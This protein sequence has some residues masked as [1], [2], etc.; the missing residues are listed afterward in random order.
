MNSSSSRSHSIFTICLIV[1]ET[2]PSSNNNTDIDVIRISKLNLVDLAGSESAGK[3]GASGDRQ[4]EASKINKSLL[5]LGRVINALT[6]T[7]Q[8]IPYRESKLTRLLQDS[9]GGRTKTCIIATITTADLALDE[10][11]NTL[12]YMSRAKKIKIYQR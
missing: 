10:T 1:K 7:K 2:A 8:H 4:Q 11:T 9:L 3:S 6:E 5:T 12:E